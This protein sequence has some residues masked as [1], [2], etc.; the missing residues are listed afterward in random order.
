MTCSYAQHVIALFSKVGGPRSRRKQ[1]VD[2]VTCAYCGGSGEDPKYGNG[3]KCPVCGATGQVRVKPPVVTCLKCSGTGREGGDLSC[4]ACKGKGVV[5][6]RPEAT[7][8]PSCKGTGEEGV[9]CCIG[10]KGQGIC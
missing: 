5:S 7:T 3:S 6:V 10:C 1:F 9:F 8:C 2:Q 4:L